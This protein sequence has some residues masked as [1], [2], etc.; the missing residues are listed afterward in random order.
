M[1]KVSYTE[2][3]NLTQYS[4]VEEPV[5]LN[6]ITRDNGI[7][8]EA[9]KDSKDTADEAV[10]IA[11]NASDTANYAKGVADNVASDLQVTNQNVSDLDARVTQNEADI[12]LLQ[13]AK[14]TAL[15][16]KIDSNT[17]LINSLSNELDSVEAEVE[18]HGNR[19]DSDEADIRQLRTDVD[20]LRSDFTECC[21][22]VNEHLGAIDSEQI[23]QNGRLDG[24]ETRMSSAEVRL[25]NLETEDETITGQ[26]EILTNR[27]NQLL[28]DLDPTNVQSALA[29]TQQ[30]IQNTNQILELVSNVSALEEQ[31]GNETLITTAQ[32]LTGAINELASASTV[33]DSQLDA[34][35]ERA[36]QNKVLTGII[37]TETL[38]TV[39][40]TITG[41]L[42]ELKSALDTV[43]GREA[44]HY[45]NLSNGVSGVDSRVSALETTVGDSNSGLVKG[46]ADANSDID[47]IELSLGD[48][49]VTVGDNSSGLVKGLA[50]AQS[51]I[52]ALQSTVGDNSAGLV[53]DVSANATAISALEGTIGDNTS[54]LVKDVADLQSDVGALE[55]TVGNNSA[56][57]VK[58]V[59]DLETVVGDSSA[60][61][62]KDVGDAQND[63]SDIQDVIPSGASSSNKLAT[64]SDIKD[65]KLLGIY[66]D[67]NAHTLPADWS[68]CHVFVMAVDA[69]SPYQERNNI[70]ME[71]TFLRRTLTDLNKSSLA[72]SS[73]RY[74]TNE[75]QGV[76]Y[77]FTD[78]TIQMNW[79]YY[80]N[81]QNN[82]HS[83][84][85]VY[86]K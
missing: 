9:L 1:S 15:E 6:D 84:S 34:T 4:E 24:L 70:C 79:F 80:Q 8:D 41:A 36:V 81:G 76:Q 14:I 66:N 27:V 49:I 18:A 26:V 64:A 46:L 19:L 85:V 54:G 10:S 45:T 59:A 71:V 47:A 30:V 37:G 5:F 3:Y 56:G 29:L 73:S 61:L 83:K 31:A 82:T 75:Q 40:Q 52:T 48:V 60:G 67:T 68:V 33:I 65:W 72:V 7:I 51:E 44:T 43:D 62:V 42:N 78:T 69:T 12:A 35:S 86:Y 25:D 13:P 50:D 53:H 55:I 63:I 28:S 57:L 74:L 77:T 16:N 38:T 32:T 23:V 21:D 11:T 22:T 20:S 2:N 17:N 39:A 58:K